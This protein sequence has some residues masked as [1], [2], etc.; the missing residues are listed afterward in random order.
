MCFLKRIPAPPRVSSGPSTPISRSCSI[1]LSFSSPNR[2]LC[3]NS[4]PAVF[5]ARR[6]C[7]SLPWPLEH[8]P[9]VGAVTRF[10]RS[11][12]GLAQV[13]FEKMDA[14]DAKAHSGPAAVSSMNSTPAA[15][16]ARRMGQIVFRCPS[17]GQS[18]GHFQSDI[19]LS[20]IVFSEVD[21][22]L[23]KSSLYFDDR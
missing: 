11:D 10:E 22:G 20:D 16:N 14:L 2:P 17:L 12:I 4:T 21:A 19:D 8:C 15:C 23:F 13:F 5:N 3:L 7:N 18:L 1:A 6:N 9:S